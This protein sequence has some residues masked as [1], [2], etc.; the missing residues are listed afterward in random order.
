MNWIDAHVDGLLA[1]YAGLV[2]AAVGLLTLRQ[3]LRRSS[4][5]PKPARKSDA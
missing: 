5:P 2:L 4:K 1:V 3:A